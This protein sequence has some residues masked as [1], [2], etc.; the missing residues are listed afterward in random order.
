M[1]LSLTISGCKI[2]QLKFFFLVFFQSKMTGSFTLR[3][4]E[5]ISV[6]SNSISSLSVIIPIFLFF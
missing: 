5:M 2:P 4:L 3:S 1:L 6:L